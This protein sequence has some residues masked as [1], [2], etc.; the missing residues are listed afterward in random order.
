MAK[1]GKKTKIQLADFESAGLFV[2]VGRYSHP[3]RTIRSYEIFLVKKGTLL[4][5][6]EDQR[7]EV[8]KDECLLLHPN[9]LHG[10]AAPY[11]KGLEFYWLHF[12]LPEGLL[13]ASLLEL[14]QH[15]ISGRVEIM[16]EYLQRLLSDRKDGT[17]SKDKAD[18]MTTLIIKEAVVRA[19]E[20]RKEGN[21][22][23]I[24]ADKADAVINTDFHNEI[25]TADIAQKLRCNPDYLGRIYR[26]R[27]GITLIASLHR[28]KIQEAKNLLIESDLNISEISSTCGFAN[29]CYFRKVFMKETGMSPREFRSAHLRAGINT[30]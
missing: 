5:F 3:T 27:Y 26:Q 8:G 1:T 21:N 23:F 29:V 22:K 25:S 19:Y 11:I 9:R 17:L 6:E 14:P 12:Y 18:L 2:S 15:F 4:M 7:F 28:R 30:K 20:S 24:L 16:K 10:G 13:K